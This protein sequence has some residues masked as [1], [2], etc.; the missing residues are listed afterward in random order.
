MRTNQLDKTICGDCTFRNY[1]KR[2][3]FVYGR[4][5]QLTHW[6]TAQIPRVHC[7]SATT[8]TKLEDCTRSTHDDDAQLTFKVTN[9]RTI[10]SSMKG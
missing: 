2:Q 9:E 4:R 6:Q 7:A 10:D 1:S 5:D 8:T 3:E